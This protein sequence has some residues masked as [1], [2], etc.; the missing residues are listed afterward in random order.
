[1]SASGN[2][3]M[4]AQD[5]LNGLNTSAAEITLPPATPAGR[6]VDAAN[7]TPVEPLA[8]QDASLIHLDQFRADPR[9]A[10][11]NGQGETVVILDTG[12]NLNHPFFGGPRFS[13]SFGLLVDFSPISGAC[14]ATG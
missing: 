5:G 2:A 7:A 8:Q 1:M 14:R 12:I 10:G 6:A 11:S 3:T 4:A 13:E 9:F